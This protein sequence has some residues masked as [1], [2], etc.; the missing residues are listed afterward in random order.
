MTLFTAYSLFSGKKALPLF[1]KI[2]PHFVRLILFIL[3]AGFIN[4]CTESKKN[5]IHIAQK[6]TAATKADI[7]KGE[8]LSET[9]CAMC[10]LNPSPSLL[11][12]KTWIKGVLP[13][14]GPRLGIFEH[15][16]IKY[17]LEYTGN[18]PKDLYPDTALISQKE[19]QKILDYFYSKAPEKL[20]FPKPKKKIVISSLFFKAVTPVYH[21]KA[22]PMVS[23]LRMDPGDKVIYLNN[24]SSNKFM[25]FNKQLK[26]IN[27]LHSVSPIT[28]IQILNNSTTQPGK[29]DLLLTFIGSL[30]PSDARKGSVMRGTYNPKT[31]KANTSYYVINHVDRPVKSYM[32]DLDGD[33]KP[34]YIIDGF[35]NH[36]GSLFWLK[37]LGNERVSKKRILSDTPGCMESRI[38]DFNGDDRP[39]IIAL[40]SQN[41]EAIFLFLNRG[42]GKFKRKTLLNF[43][44]VYGSSSFEIHDFNNDGKPDILYTC[45]DNADYS[46]IYKP[47]HGVYIFLNQG[48]YKFKKAWFY[49]IDGAYNAK[50]RDFEHDGRLDIAVIS[51]FA[52][53]KKRPQ[54]GFI[55]FR[56]NGIRKN[57]SFSFTPYHPP[58]TSKERWLT[59]DVADWNGDGYDDILLGNFSMGP[60]GAMNP[61]FAKKMQDKWSHAP[62]FVLLVNQAGTK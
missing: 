48:N 9:Y 55:F 41:T 29:R 24:A 58:A 32:A 1:N 16:N 6:L 60:Q 56:N 53:Y 13:N 36:R 2:K 22:S 38:M 10:H 14:M 15:D 42:G 26:L 12:K 54:E 21:G 5:D 43:P 8:K 25:V 33:G 50:A 31:E 7:A 57:G 61:K 11:D 3:A 23:A 59:M 46:T 19:W 45:G 37:N 27:Q 28:G 39:D 47:Y 51:F 34:D 40:C 4:S 44:P 17:P 18:L 49:H 30:R 52:N 20:E 35:G 62:L